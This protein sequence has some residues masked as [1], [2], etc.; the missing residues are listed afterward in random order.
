MPKYEKTADRARFYTH[1]LQE[2]RRLP[3]V[4]AAAYVSAIPL[5]MQG[6]IWPVKIPGRDPADHTRARHAALR[7]SR[8][9]RRARHSAP[10]RAAMSAT[11]TRARRPSPPS[12]A[13]PSPGATGRA[14][15]RSGVTSNSPYPAAPSSAWSATSAPAARKA[16]ASRR[17]TSRISRSADGNI[18][19]YVPKDLVLRTSAPPGAIVPAL[20]RIIA[21][22]DAE[23]PI[24]NVRMLGD[25][26][27]AETQPRAV[28]VRALA[29]FAAHRLPA[30][31]HRHSRPALVHRIQPRPGNRRAP[32]AGCAA[33]AISSV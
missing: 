20:R 7:H 18:I 1:V 28:Q 25:V 21:A 32:R 8:L 33:Y 14:R 26:V 23:L 4:S 10:H 30:R 5:A 24:S 31:R 3:G 17:S 12:S 22:A 6:G 13:K 29:A 2:A 9:F 19:G 15:I 27:E 16:K 11:P